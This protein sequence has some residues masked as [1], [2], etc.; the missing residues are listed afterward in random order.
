MQKF[1]VFSLGFLLGLIACWNFRVTVSRQDI[2]D[3][4]NSIEKYRVDAGVARSNLIRTID[5]IEQCQLMVDSM[6][7]DIQHTIFETCKPVV[8]EDAKRIP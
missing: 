3:I 4:K 7:R 5:K 6:K 2:F 1:L 8:T